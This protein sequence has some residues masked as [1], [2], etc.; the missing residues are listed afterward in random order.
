MAIFYQDIKRKRSGRMNL[1]T[2][3]EFQQNNIKRLNKEYDVEMYS[4]KSWGGKAF[5]AEQKIRELKKFL[6]RSKRIKKV[7]GKPVKP[8]DL[9]KKATFNLSN[10]RSVKY[11]YAPQQV[12]NKSLYV[13]TEKDFQEVYGFHR[14]VRIKEARQRSE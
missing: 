4:T 6:L 1:Q 14:L 7:E 8:N 13:T 9:I 11:G 10:T 5:A 2:D 3:Q 12:E